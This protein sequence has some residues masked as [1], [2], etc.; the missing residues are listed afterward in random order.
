MGYQPQDKPR[1]E[2][3]TE[4]HTRAVISFFVILF[5]TIIF[6]IGLIAVEKEKVKELTKELDHFF[7]TE[8]NQT[9]SAWYQLKLPLKF[10]ECVQAGEF[11]V[12]VYIDNNKI[13]SYRGIDFNPLDQVQVKAEKDEYPSDR[14]RK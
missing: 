7:K 14:N 9:N 13:A 11:S 3:T 1:F 8:A 12:W 2:K 4:I 6:L 5:L 10:K